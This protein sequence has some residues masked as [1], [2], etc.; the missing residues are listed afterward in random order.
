M[1]SLLGGGCV[2]QLPV[3]P[4]CLIRPRLNGQG[5]GLGDSHVRDPLGTRAP[6]LSQRSSQHSKSRVTRSVPSSNLQVSMAIQLRTLFSKADQDQLAAFLATHSGK[7]SGNAVYQKLAQ[8]H[9]KHT[10]K[11]WRDH[12]LSNS[13]L[14][15]GLIRR[16][17]REC[18]NATSPHHHS[19]HPRDLR[20]N[21][22][23]LLKANWIH[24]ELLAHGKSRLA[25]VALVLENLS[26]NEYLPALETWSQ[27][28]ATLL[29]LAHIRQADLVHPTGI[30]LADSSH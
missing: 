21:E 29:Q 1:H 24:C 18:L 25:V 13:L 7:R 16:K 12:Y 27:I 15:Y 2:G 14:I 4:C 28:T 9:P 23:E 10:W 22:K 17:K 30:H 11:S 20:P 26:W 19:N 6:I 5:A 8:T 3:A